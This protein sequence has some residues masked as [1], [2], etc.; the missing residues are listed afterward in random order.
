[1]VAHNPQVLRVAVEA[2]VTVGDGDQPTNFKTAI[3]HALGESDSRYPEMPVAV[4][5]LTHDADDGRDR[6]VEGFSA[7]DWP[8][9]PAPRSAGSHHR[10]DEGGGAGANESGGDQ[11]C[12]VVQ[13]GC[14][15]N[16]QRLLAR[17]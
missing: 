5:I 6:N 7:E 13:A 2:T 1:M 14:V 11:R 10:A 12:G 4:P 15:V 3:G 16:V 9:R 17:R 8:H